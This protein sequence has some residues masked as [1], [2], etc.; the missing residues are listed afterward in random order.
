MNRFL[1]QK[2]DIIIIRVHQLKKY[3]NKI[4]ITINDID[5]LEK[6]NIIED[7]IFNCSNYH[8]GDNLKLY[9]DKN[10]SWFY[11]ENLFITNFVKYC[12]D[13]KY[14]LERITEFEKLLGGQ[15]NE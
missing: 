2:G 9:I 12:F 3:T 8:I 4:K 15:I 7:V 5:V 13:Q 11:A 10:N 1:S 6:N 14:I